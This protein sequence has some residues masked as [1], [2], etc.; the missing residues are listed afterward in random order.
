MHCLDRHRCIHISRPSAV[1][2]LFLTKECGWKLK[3]TF[4]QW[5]IINDLFI[6]AKNKLFEFRHYSITI[7][8][9]CMKQALSYGAYALSRH[10]YNVPSVTY[11][12]TSLNYFFVSS[13]WIVYV[14]AVIVTYLTRVCIVEQCLLYCDHSKTLRYCSRAYSCVL[15][16]GIVFS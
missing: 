16:H 3:L 5:N 10:S 4:T 14:K 7:R 15:Y 1:C 12:L 9:R 8:Y 2:W 11:D 13:L 6:A